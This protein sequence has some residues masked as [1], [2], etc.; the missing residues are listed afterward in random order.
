MRSTPTA[1]S[2]RAFAEYNIEER[3]TTLH[4]SALV[5]SFREDGPGPHMTQPHRHDFVELIWISQGS[6]AHLI[7]TSEFRVAP[8]T[9]HIIAPGQVHCWSPDGQALDGTLVLFREEF[10]VSAA[11]L[12]ARTIRGGMTVPDA[13][14]ARRID[15]MLEDLRDELDG[16]AEDRDEV[17][18]YLLSALVTMCARTR[19]EPARPRHTLARAFLR[20]VRAEPRATL[21]V[22]DCAR[23]LNVTGNHLAEVVAADLGRTPSAVIRAAVLLEAERLLCRTAL[24]CAQI[25]AELDFGDPSYFSRFFRR[26]TGST[27]SAYRSARGLVA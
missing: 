3:A 7:D 18:R 12:P 2:A 27:P 16:D 19:I 6:G 4:G 26:E 15:R 9:L 17:V 8:R 13:A 24:T 11:D 25:A 5:G 22:A 10:L 14:T 23:R 1:P 21:T 20:I